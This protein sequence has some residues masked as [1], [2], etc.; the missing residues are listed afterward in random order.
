MKLEDEIIWVMMPRSIVVGGSKVLQNVDFLLEH[1][2]LS[3]SR[4]SQF[5][6]S[7]LWKPQIL[8]S[9]N[10]IWTSCH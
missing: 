2:M 6:S 8:H 9:W 1:N 10:K 4:R 7:L 3:Q 5:E